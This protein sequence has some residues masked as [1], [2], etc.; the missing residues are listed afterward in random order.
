M[1]HLCETTPLHQVVQFPTRFRESNI[2]SLLDLTFVQKPEE[3]WEIDSLP[4]LGNSDHCVIRLVV[5][6]R[7][8]N[9][10]PPRWVKQ[11]HRVDPEAV[12]LQARAL[13]WMPH[14]GEDAEA[15]WTRAKDNIRLLDSPLVPWVRINQM[16]KPRWMSP[17]M[18]RAR[19]DKRRSWAD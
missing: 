15:I 16:R 13:D 17:A 4:S 11:Y 5:N 7:G 1:V 14:E 10:P 8:L 19:D 9:L 2:S 6:T 12:L 3:V 18:R